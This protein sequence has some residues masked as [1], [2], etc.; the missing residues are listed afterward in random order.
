VD[1]VFYNGSSLSTN[2]SLSRFPKIT[3]GFV[4]QAYIST[5]VVTP[6]RQYD[7]GAWNQPTKV[8]AAVTGIVVTKGNPF[9]LSFT[10]NTGLATTL[11]QADNVG[12]PFKVIFGQ[13]FASPASA[14]YITNPPPLQQFYFITTQ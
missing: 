9:T 1:R 12:D 2:G 13:Q 7:G 6:G 11:W 4:P 14:F 5:S 8:P 3:D 10:A